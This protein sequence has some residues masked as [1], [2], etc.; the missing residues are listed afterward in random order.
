MGI[1][2]ITITCDSFRCVM[3]RACE[4][5]IDEI[6][7]KVEFARRIIDDILDAIDDDL[8]EYI[9]RHIWESDREAE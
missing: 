8:V 7:T 3:G 1:D 4:S 5:C 9:D 6:R 2:R